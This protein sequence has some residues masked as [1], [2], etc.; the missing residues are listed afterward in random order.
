M[1]LFLEDAWQ[2]RGTLG[3]DCIERVWIDAK[4]TEDR[5]SNLRGCHETVHCART[6]SALAPTNI[7]AHNLMLATRVDWQL[8]EAL[9]ASG[10]ID[11]GP[12]TCHAKDLKEGNE[13]KDLED[14]STGARCKCIAPFFGEGYFWSAAALPPLLRV[15]FS[16][17]N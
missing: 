11:P 15:M 7:Y 8:R 16:H 13:V 10:M 9:A 1:V 6:S 2:H 4:Q 3:P 5:R 14:W 12:L 17:Q